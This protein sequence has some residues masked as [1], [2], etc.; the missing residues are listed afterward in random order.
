MRIAVYSCF[1]GK[2][3]P[4]NP[5]ALSSWD[6]ADRI[7]F[8]DRT[9][10]KVA[11]GVQLRTEPPSDEPAH[12]ASR[13][14]KLMPHRYL[15]DYDVSIYIDNNSRLLMDPALII[16]DLDVTRGDGLFCFWHHQRDCVY[17]EGEACIRLGKD[18]PERIAQHIAM[19]RDAGMPEQFGL[20]K[21]TFLIRRHNEERI[22]A[23]G[24]AWF[25]MLKNG[26]C[27]DQL[28]LPYLIWSGAVTPERIPGTAAQNDY[29]RWPEFDRKKRKAIKFGSEPTTV[30]GRLARK[31][32]F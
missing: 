12:I 26:S 29:M 21:G 11:P 6:S 2:R 20:F 31:F 27:R 5:A 25:E 10:L 7:L 13:R 17:E 18:D 22:K 28:S 32:G 30:L 19:L 24:D 9:D 15:S 4:Y 3:E 23:F 16:Q 14:A 8:T 1:Y